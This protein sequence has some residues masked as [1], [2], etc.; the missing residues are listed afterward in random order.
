[1]TDNYSLSDIRAVTQGENGGFGA[2]NGAWWIIILFL[3]A[4]MGWGGRG[5]GGGYGTDGGVQNNYV[6]ASDFSQL[7]RQVADGFSS[8]ERKL[9]GVNNGLCSGFYQEAQLINGVNMQNA[10]NT[11]AV[12]QTLTQGFAGLNTGMVQQGYETRLG[13]QNIGTQMGQCCCDLRAGQADLKYAIAQGNC[14]LGQTITMAARDIVDNQNANYRALHDEIVAGR[15][16]DKNAQI[17]SLERQVF[18]Q[19]LAASQAIQTSEI[20][21]QLR[22]CP[23]PAY[24]VPNPN[25]CYQNVTYA[26]QQGCGCA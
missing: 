18:S 23:I 9:D 24:P 14:Q 17:A 2:G 6:L 5:F 11:A 22:P 3:F 20:L 12:Q 1:M 8:T 16:E 25:C 7:S 4:F 15:I 21:G 19:Q 26:N 10:N 13:I